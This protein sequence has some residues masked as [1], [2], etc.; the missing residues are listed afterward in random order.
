MAVGDVKIISHE[1]KILTWA[2]AA[3]ISAPANSDPIAK[4]SPIMTYQVIATAVSGTVSVTAQWQV[5]NDDTT[6]TPA[7]WLSYGAAVS[8]AAGTS[9]ATTGFPLV[10]A[11]T[12]AM[13]PWRYV[14][15]SVSAL[16][17]SGSGPTLYAIVGF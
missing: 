13:A 10:N 9:P 15:L 17:A 4:T 14:R 12:L 16:S 8:I 7:N 1:K 6:G 3:S 11:D 2:G 5:T